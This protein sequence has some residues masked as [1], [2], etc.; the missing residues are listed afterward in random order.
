MGLMGGF[1][2]GRS[3]SFFH[4]SSPYLSNQLQVYIESRDDIDVGI[5]LWLR[6]DGA[7]MKIQ[8]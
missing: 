3:R 7:V 8:L 1:E 4:P 5:Y 2:A 6:L